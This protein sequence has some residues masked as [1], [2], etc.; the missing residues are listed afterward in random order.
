M[1]A[2][3][4]S[5]AP[6]RF[7]VLGEVVADPDRNVMLRHGE[8]VKLEPKVM[9]L[10]AYLA[11]NPGRIVGKDELIARVWNGTHVV[12]EAVQRAISLL[13]SALEDDARRPRVVETVPGR[14]Y[15]LMITPQPLEHPVVPTSSSFAGSRPLALVLTALLAGLVIGG[16]LLNQ[17]REDSIAPEA[18]TP[19]PTPRALTESAPRA[20]APEPPPPAR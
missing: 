5:A 15:R 17:R 9:A 3:P 11:A 13:R 4:D 10:L 6:S 14:G 16:V 7:F 1:T 2:S 8:I 20:V 12:D 18:P 19:S